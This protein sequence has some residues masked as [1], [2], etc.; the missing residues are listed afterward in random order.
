MV[1][2]P[3]L[4]RDVPAVEP[5]PQE[6]VP[7]PVDS[8]ESGATLPPRLRLLCVGPSEPSWLDFTMHLHAE[9][10]IEP[11]LRWMSTTNDA[12]ALLRESS[13]DC[14]IVHPDPGTEPDALDFLQAVRASGCDDPIVIVASQ[15]DDH[16]W[17]Q[18]C[19]NDAELLLSDRD[20]AALA[21]VPFLRRAMRLVET[22]RDRQQLLQADRR[23]L[24]RERDEAENLLNQQRQ[25]L[26]GLDFIAPAA[27]AVATSQ[28]SPPGGTSPGHSVLPLEINEFY[29]E[30]L[31]TYVIMGSGNLGPEIAKLAELLS[32]AGLTPRQA[33]QLHLE[34][35]EA[36]VR[37]LGNRST[38]H[39]MS[40]AD[41][42]ALELMI[43]LGECYQRRS[44]DSALL[45]LN[46]NVAPRA[47]A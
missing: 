33:M 42:L 34:R 7:R 22:S 5:P 45:P 46:E 6:Q 2:P 47:A 17:Q 8:H 14:L 37:G 29:Q 36:L 19:Q 21:L 41:L 28:A 26:F 16:M 1:S 3:F 10:C 12:L 24:S 4:K 27:S 20:F 32:L 38:R 13:F 15:A 31:R 44:H 23:R 43:H 11:C 39:V 30:L 35:V 9:G 18:T 25:L 40:R